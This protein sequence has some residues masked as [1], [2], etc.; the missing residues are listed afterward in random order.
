MLRCLPAVYVIN[1]DYEIC[2]TTKENGIL[3]INVGGKRYDEENS[4]VLFSEKNYYKIRIPQEELDKHKQYEIV[5]IGNVNRQAYFT[6]GDPEKK[7][8]FNFKPI[9]KT[10]NIK[11][12]H[13]AD[14]HGF[15]D[16]ALKSIYYFGD[17]YDLLIVNGDI[18]EVETEQDYFNVYKFVGELSKGEIP[19][20]FVRGNH[21]CRGKLAEK[22][23][24]YFPNNNKALYYDFKVG[25]LKGIA[26]DCGED[27]VDFMS[28]Y[29]PTNHFSPYRRKE[30]E[31]IKN[32]KG[33]Y[34]FVV[35]HICPSY[36]T[37]TKGGEH[38]IEREL[39]AEWNE[40]L[41]KRNIKF[42]LMG[43]FH[44]EKVLPVNCEK[45][46]LP[47]PYPIIVGSGLYD[48]DLD[49]VLVVSG[50]II[51]NKHSAEIIFTSSEKT[52]TKKEIITF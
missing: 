31:F 24:D 17:D 44:K 6:K 1:N 9:T 18:A 14:V 49:N 48:D 37:G 41:V 2:V 36:T 8:T 26:L 25:P 39:Y 23:T 45:A 34:F 32:L 19:V 52:I 13:L 20:L 12:Y 27:K 15:F 4:G 42:F 50:N 40:L 21:D 46:T 33:D 38:D 51:L 10:E 43:H 22:F 47:N 11:I 29:G 5:Y 30:T 3:Y 16:L 7:I 28:S 35:S